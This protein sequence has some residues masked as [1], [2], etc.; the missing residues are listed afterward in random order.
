[1]LALVGI[2]SYV[3]ICPEVTE[4]DIV[5]RTGL[6]HYIQKIV[7][8][9]LEYEGHFLNKDR[10]LRALERYEIQP[11]QKPIPLTDYQ[12]K[13][14]R[15]G[16]YCLNCKSYEVKIGRTK[17]SCACGFTEERDMAILRTICE[18]GVLTF[19]RDIK[20]GGLSNFLGAGISHVSIRKVLKKYFKEKGRGRYTTYTN[21]PLPYH[22]LIQ[23][24]NI[25]SSIEITADYEKF[26]RYKENER[27]RLP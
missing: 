25:S 3:E 26:Y 14:M 13:Q 16:I 23:K 6:K 12:M 9:E 8:Q 5:Q 4:I 19:D 15:T 22:K 20:M 21:K 18:Y 24:L 27:S 2:D 7:E 17:T 10:S 11:L 1:M